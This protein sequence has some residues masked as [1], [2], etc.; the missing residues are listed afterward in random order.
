MI[1]RLL[2][3]NGE[4]MFTPPDSKSLTPRTLMLGNRE[5]TEVT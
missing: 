4:G 5:M 1:N 3:K 2:N